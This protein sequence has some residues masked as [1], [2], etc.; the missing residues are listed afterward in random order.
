[1]KKKNRLIVYIFLVLFFFISCEKKDSRYPELVNRLVSQMTLEEKA[2]QMTMMCLSEVTVTHDKHLMLDEDV[3]RAMIRDHHVGAFLSG[4]GSEAEW[5]AFTR[6]AQ[7]IAMEESQSG[8]PVIFGIDHIHGANYVDEGTFFP[9]NLGL[10]CSFDTALVGEV[11]EITAME[12]TAAGLLWN[13]APVLDV[14]VNPYWPRLYETFGED[15]LVCSELGSRFIMHYDGWK[16]PGRNHPVSCGKHFIGYSNPVSG[17]DRSPSVINQQALYEIFVPPFREAIQA[18][19]KTVMVNSG[20]VNGE[21]V[22]ISKHLLHDIL[23][24][25]LG[26]E[27]VILS[28]IKDIQ[29]LVDMHF[30]VE[31]YEEAVKLSVDAGI[32][33][34]MSCSDLRFPEII[35]DKV[36]AGKISE[37]R[38]DESVR[39]ILYLK[40]QA[41][42]FEQPYPPET[43]SQ[44]NPLIRREHLQWAVRAAEKS[45][46]LL[47]ND[48]VLPL[49]TG[50][51][52]LLAGF[53][54]SSRKML[55]G[56]W[57][58]EWLGADENRFPPDM[59][60]LRES[61]AVLWGGRLLPP[62]ASGSIKSRKKEFLDAASSADA[63]ILTIGEEPYSEF[64]GN[65]ED[66]ALSASHQELAELAVSTGKPVVLVLI[67]GR[68]RL[69]GELAEKASAVLFAG[70][71]GIGGGDALANILSGRTNPSGKLS[72]TYPAQPGHIV[73]YF[74]K[75]TDVYK[76]LYPFGHG[77]SYTSFEY[78]GLTVSDSIVK[79]GR[80]FTVSVEV[81]NTGDRNGEEVVLLFSHDLFGKTT[82]PIRKLVRFSKIML[83]PGEKQTVSFIMFPGKDLSYPDETGKVVLETGGF[84]LYCGEQ[85]TGFRLAN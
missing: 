34:S 17:Y 9:H 18:G 62:V 41:G 84:E 56:A 24:E 45:I 22:H 11:A 29:K 66:L 38:I 76:P 25:K 83:T 47:K 26:F 49:D 46:V 43:G 36:R 33:M 58:L 65:I 71:P 63:I 53:A 12:T 14:G 44:P 32:D 55:N 15:P 70:Y 82:R 68:P 19:L 28:D 60:T 35:V 4:S 8:I 1:M 37:A 79:A 50:K 23:R 7:E 75:S 2:G 40:Y 10:A 72:F 31:T 59:H 20:E 5:R 78:S 67:E 30:A 48:G 27:G 57:T 69:L 6:R 42:L 85:M 39:R 3:F 16:T 77:M 81:T 54:S 13:F 64:K 80:S 21:P 73:P 52:V 61:M 74:R 51:R